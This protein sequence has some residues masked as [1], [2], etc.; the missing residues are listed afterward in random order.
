[1]RSAKNFRCILARIRDNQHQAQNT[2]EESNRRIYSSHWRT[3]KEG[4]DAQ[5]IS[6]FTHPPGIS[7]ICRLGANLAVRIGLLVEQAPRF[8][9]G[10]LQSGHCKAQRR[11]EP[12]E[13]SEVAK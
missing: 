9:N 1:M 12:A 8:T 13:A 5:W 6:H 11:G 2:A 7:R 3:E 10:G 4:G